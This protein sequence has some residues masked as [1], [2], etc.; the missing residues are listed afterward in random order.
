MPC[1][2]ARTVARRPSPPAAGR[3]LLRSAPP[4][5]SNLAA[6]PGGASE[7]TQTGL[8]RCPRGS[9]GPTAA[10]CGWSTAA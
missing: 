1:Y 7:R 5:P 6:L 4:P 2:H 8:L 10:R 3:L 9:V